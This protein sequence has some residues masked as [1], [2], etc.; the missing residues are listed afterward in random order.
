MDAESA[1]EGGFGEGGFGGAFSE[2]AAVHKDDME[3]MGGDEADVVADHELGESVSGAEFF[4]EF[5]EEAFAGGV[6]AGAGLVEDEEFGIAQEGV[7]QEDALQFAAGEG[8]E[9]TVGDV[10]GMDGGEKPQGLF[11]DGPSDAGQP[12]GEALL[13]AGKEFEGGEGEVAVGGE[14]LGDEAHAGAGGGAVGV[15]ALDGAGVGE[16]AE[17]GVD[18]GRLPGAV[19]ADEGGDASRGDMRGGVFDDRVVVADD[20]NLMEMETDGRHGRFL[21]A[22]GER[23]WI[24]YC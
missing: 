11:A 10:F 5:A 6:D 8:G 22:H 4:E 1:F 2:D 24:T 15:V 13:G 12:E 14:A 21:A 20:A 17:E 7:G 16:E 3:G 23:M 9:G 18:E 19:G